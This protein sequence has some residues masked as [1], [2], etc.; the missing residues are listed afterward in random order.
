MV[1]E[2]LMEKTRRLLQESERSLPNVY[3]DLRAQGSDVG[4]F[5]LRKFSAGTVKDPSVNRVEE[6]Y[7]YLTKQP[8]AS[9]LE[10]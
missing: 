10:E 2:T 1:E 4:Y 9:V 5:W 3:A 7:R 8:L 6:L